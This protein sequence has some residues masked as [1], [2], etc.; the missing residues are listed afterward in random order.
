MLLALSDIPLRSASFSLENRWLLWSKARLYADRLVL[1]GWGLWERYWRQ[2]PLDDIE[3]VERDEMQLLL[4]LEDGTD[5]AIHLNRAE[6]WL[7]AIQVHR[8]VQQQ[9][10]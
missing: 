9:R 8:E 10:S 2:I 6:R 3:K 1:S 5:I 4:H 7:T